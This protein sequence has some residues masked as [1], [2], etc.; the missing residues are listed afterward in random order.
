MVLQF[1]LTGVW[2]R[3]LTLIILG[4]CVCA[5]VCV[6]S[7]D[8]L[9]C[10]NLNKYFNADLTNELWH[11]TVYIVSIRQRGCPHQAFWN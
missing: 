7:Y 4:A 10:N 5:C 1:G 11:A 2:I 8:A 6:K 3:I 9:H